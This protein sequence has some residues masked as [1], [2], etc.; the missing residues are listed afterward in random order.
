MV[1]ALRRNLAQRSR[2]AVDLIETHISYVLVCGE[3]AYKIKKAL[4]TPF[5]DQSTVML[6]Q[7]AC[8][9]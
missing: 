4:R 6:R 3:L 5:L 9:E 7:R 8:Q 1:Q 2:V